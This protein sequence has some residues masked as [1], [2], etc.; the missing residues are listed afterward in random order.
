MGGEVP[1]SDVP[2]HLASIPPAGKIANPR[3][4]PASDIPDHLAAT[5]AT[6]GPDASFYSAKTG[7]PDV[8][9][10]PGNFYDKAMGP[11]AIGAASTLVPGSGLAANALTGA[12]ISVANDL[13]SGLINAAYG[14]PSGLSAEGELKSAATG[15]VTGMVAPALVSAS[16]AHGA[17]QAA[18]G[19]IDEATSTAASLVNQKADIKAEQ[20]ANIEKAGTDANATSEAAI[21]KVKDQVAAD[22]GKRKTQVMSGVEGQREDIATAEAKRRTE[23]MLGKTP[24]QFVASEANPD[25]A[26]VAQARASAQAPFFDSARAMHEEVGAKFEPYLG[27][28]RNNPVDAVGLDGLRGRI[29]DV[30][31]WA[32]QNGQNINDPTLKKIFDEVKGSGKDENALN[33]ALIDQGIPA[34]AVAK[35][36]PEGK[37]N[38]AKQA[39][40]QGFMD[41][42]VLPDE[43]LT[44]GR[45]WGLRAQANKVLATSNNSAVRYAAHQF[46][47]DVTEQLPNVPQA[48]RNQY[49]TERSLFPPALA[50]KVAQARNPQEVGEAIFG[51]KSDDPTPAQVPLNIIR[52]ATTPEAQEGLKTAFADR[53]LGN[54]M[55][56]DDLSKMNYNVVK[57]L[58]GPDAKSV[59]A[60]LGADG[61]VKSAPWEAILQHS[62][63]AQKAFS[64]AWT[65]SIQSD[66]AQATQ[67]AIIQGKQLLAEFPASAE[68]S[69]IQAQLDAAVL[70][71]DK[72]KI[73]ETQIPDPRDAGV[74]AVMKLQP[75]RIER[76]TAMRASMIGLGFSLGGYRYLQ[77]SPVGQVLL[78]S[79]GAL[80]GGR[81]ALRYA[82][83]KPGIAGA[84]VDVLS[85]PATVRNAATLGRFLAGTTQGALLQGAKAN[86][87]LGPM[88]QNQAA[89]NPATP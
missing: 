51:S 22:E 2:E 83:T 35:M 5:P 32:Q 33:A 29:A 60:L 76:I 6:N 86:G 44:Q 31:N 47:D 10:H 37:L 75:A 43:N 88:P 71:A 69:R 1:D 15:A 38:Y 28:V 41:K 58:Y 50:R 49:S 48:V 21:K 61:K 54:N 25:F 72:L 74:Q 53:Y 80:I 46:V 20:T 36:T 55:T 62:P 26:Q 42:S 8:P 70:P 14:K 73:L 34:G 16:G 67:K 78:G 11:L 56:P 85:N 65:Q 3:E 57:A 9:Q 19:A 40:Q 4:V 18:R 52:R 87:A 66:Q 68:R 81:A 82:L 17:A 39:V 79:A 23:G 63:E 7:L 13:Y 27:P 64:D 59:Y 84:F 89:Q 24:G 12:G 45:L 77:N 30:E